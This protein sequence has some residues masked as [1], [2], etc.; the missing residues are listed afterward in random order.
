MHRGRGTIPMRNNMYP[1]NPLHTPKNINNKYILCRIGIF[2]NT[3]NKRKYL[4]IINQ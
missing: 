3:E 4:P 1:V 2:F